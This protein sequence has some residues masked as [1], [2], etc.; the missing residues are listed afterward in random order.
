M[1]MPEKVTSIIDDDR[2][3]LSIWTHHD[4]G[5]RTR[6]VGG[7]YDKIVPYHENGQMAPVLWFAVYKGDKIAHKVNGARIQ[8]VNY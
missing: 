2:E 7:G 6:S 1:K 8:N 3:I 5:F 4:A